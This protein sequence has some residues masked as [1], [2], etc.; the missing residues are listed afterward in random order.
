VCGFSSWQQFVSL[1]N[2]VANLARACIKCHNRVLQTMNPFDIITNIVSDKY[3]C[4]LCKEGI[5]QNT[6]RN[7]PFR[8]IKYLKLRTKQGQSLGMKQGNA[9]R[10]KVVHF[11]HHFRFAG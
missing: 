8:A 2:I 10:E 1:V 6:N 11:F 9:M 7:V 3:F 5:L 4:H